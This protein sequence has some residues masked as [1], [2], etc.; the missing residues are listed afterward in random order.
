M[1]SDNLLD[2]TYNIN[3]LQG[4]YSKINQLPFIQT[5][6]H[7]DAKR[8]KSKRLVIRSVCNIEDDLLEIERNAKAVKC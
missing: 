4:V 2:G 7:P 1:W 5:T 8:R 6:T 3:S